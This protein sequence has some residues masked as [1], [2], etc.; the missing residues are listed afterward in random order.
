MAD[1][2]REKWLAEAKRRMRSAGMRSGQSRTAVMELLARDGR[3]LMSAQDVVDAMSARG[4]SSRASVYRV[5][6]TLHELGM[7]HR[8][9]SGDGVARFE[10]ADPD[11]H[12]HHAVNEAT[13]EITTFTDP[14]LEA[15]IKAIAARLGLELT[16]HDVILRGT[17]AR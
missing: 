2:A 12:H 3:C 7:L 14:V 5:L 6:D 16:S 15:S 17:P 1:D 4:A 8:I 11:E 10:I 13:G 9:D